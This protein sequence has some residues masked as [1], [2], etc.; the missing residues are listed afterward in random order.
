MRT[1]PGQEEVHILLLRIPHDANFLAL[2]ELYSEI[3]VHDDTI[4]C[5]KYETSSDIYSLGS[6]AFELIA[7]NPPF[8][9]S[10]GLLQLQGAK[11]PKLRNVC[12]SSLRFVIE[13]C[14]KV[15]SNN[16]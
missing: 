4:L 11:M 7:G 5:G 6:V 13:Q 14:L 1:V 2:K 10:G 9:D 3:L 8:G 12:S 16:Y 15:C